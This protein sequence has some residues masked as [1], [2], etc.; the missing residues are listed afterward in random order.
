MKP[1]APAV[2]LPFRR[3]PAEFSIGSEPGHDAVDQPRLLVSVGPDPH[4]LPGALSC[5]AH[6]P[7][8]RLLVKVDGRVLSHGHRTHRTARYGSAQLPVNV[9]TRAAT[10]AEYRGLGFA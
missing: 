9:V 3:G 2:R 5:P 1:S 7:D 8:H 6:R 10:L 4:A